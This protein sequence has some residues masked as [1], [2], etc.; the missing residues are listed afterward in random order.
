MNDTNLRSNGEAAT[1][2]RL[3]PEHVQSATA[4]IRGV[5]REHF[6]SHTETFVRDYLLVPNALDDIAEAAAGAD[7]SRLFLVQELRGHV[8]GT[9]AIHGISDDVCEL[10]R[11]FVAREWR[12][13]GLATALAQHLLEF[14]RSRHFTTVR[15][16]SNKHLTASHRLYS[17][18]GFRPCPAWTPEDERHSV[19]MQ[20]SLR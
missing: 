18:L 8:V 10:S 3:R 20:L 19:T 13:R 1:I 4:L 14:A 15:L 7:A 6:Q 9:G 12:K 2:E 17:A 5:W 16:A 11:M